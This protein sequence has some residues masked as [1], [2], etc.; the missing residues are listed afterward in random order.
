MEKKNIIIVA[1]GFSGLSVLLYLNSHKDKLGSYQIIVIDQKCNF[2]FLPMLP[3]VL[4]SWLNADRIKIK[5]KELCDKL[6]VK[7]VNST[8]KK[9]I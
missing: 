9:L 5:L 7:F 8:I 4:A 1:G 2:K 3:D 6:N